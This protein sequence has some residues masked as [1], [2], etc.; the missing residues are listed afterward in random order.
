M[1]TCSKCHSLMFRESSLHHQSADYCVDL[2][3]VQ[4]MQRESFHCV[5]CG[6]FEDVVILKN[7]AIQAQERRLI[8]DAPVIAAWATFHAA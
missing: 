6:N 2:N 1:S 7:R 3:D 5:T 4:A 8:Q